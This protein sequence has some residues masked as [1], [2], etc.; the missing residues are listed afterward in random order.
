MASDSGPNGE[1]MNTGSPEK[2]E[3]NQ[4]GWNNQPSQQ[5]P[6][7]WKVPQPSL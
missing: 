7:T 1:A 3:H 2:W 4:G 6:G 5:G